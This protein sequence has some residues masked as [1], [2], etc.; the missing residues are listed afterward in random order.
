MIAFTF[1]HAGQYVIGSTW[2]ISLLESTRTSTLCQLIWVNFMRVNELL[3]FRLQTNKL[4][5]N[6]YYESIVKM[7]YTVTRVM[8]MK[9]G[10]NWRCFHNQW[11]KFL[12]KNL[13]HTCGEW[14][15]SVN[16]QPFKSNVDLTYATSMVTMS[17]IRDF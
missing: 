13:V 17:V 12:E 11:W 9:I 15:F 4:H 3:S 2:V 7:P 6:D 1:T 14:Y 16:A 8:N 5:L 10:H